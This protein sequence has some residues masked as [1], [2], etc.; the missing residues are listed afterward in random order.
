M[1]CS[2]AHFAQTLQ[3]TW[4]TYVLIAQSIKSLVLGVEASRQD[5]LIVQGIEAGGHVHGT[6]SILVKLEPIVRA[7]KLPVV[8]SGGF[9]TGASLVAALTAGRTGDPLR[10]GLRAAGSY[11]KF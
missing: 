11:A 10:N 3:R 9:A 8:A 2:C 6:V 5:V 4:S 1:D 7:V